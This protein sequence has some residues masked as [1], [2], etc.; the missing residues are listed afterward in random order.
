MLHQT[1]LTLCGLVQGVRAM[2][3]RDMRPQVKLRKQRKLKWGEMRD[4]EMAPVLSGHRGQLY[5]IES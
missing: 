5:E 1:W 4:T 2:E 3:G